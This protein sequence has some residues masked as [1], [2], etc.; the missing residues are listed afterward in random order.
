MDK[1]E[2]EQRESLK[3]LSSERLRSRLVALGF[4]ED[5]VFSTERADLLN[6]MAQHLLTPKLV[7]P[8]PTPVAPAEEIRLRELA[9]KELEIKLTAEREQRQADKE[10]LTAQLADEKEKRKVEY[11]KWKAELDLRKA[12]VK[13]NQKR[14]DEDIELRKMEINRA[15][16][17]DKLRDEHEESLISQT[18]RY[19]DM[20]KRVL[21]N[22][23]LTL[24]T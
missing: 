19:G 21:P 20:L 15:C 13:L 7:A 11:D 2:A 8:E 6:M 3:K 12:E 18:K 23:H 24:Q 4:D 10:K 5:L 9:I 1:L 14:S 17:R 22:M 16:E